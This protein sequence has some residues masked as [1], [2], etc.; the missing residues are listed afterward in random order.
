[1]T[2]PPIISSAVFASSGAPALIA[3]VDGGG[4][5]SR[6]RLTDRNGQIIGEAHAGPANIR[7]G[8]DE[9]W[10]QILSLTWDALRGDAPLAPDLSS[11][12]LGL[13]LAG[14][15]CGRDAAALAASNPGFYSVSVSSDIHAACLGAFGGKD[16][17]IVICGT[18]SSAYMLR[19]GVGRQ[20]G[21]WG[22]KICDYGSAASVG[23]GAIRAAL[24]AHDGFEAHT[25]LTTEIMAMFNNNPIELVDWSDGAIPRD[26]GRFA[27]ICARHAGNDDP[28][29]RRLI[30]K[31]AAA[32]EA[33]VLRLKALGAPRICV[34][35]GMA[36]T[37]RPYMGETTQ[38]LLT[39][40][41]GDATWGAIALARG[42][43]TGFDQ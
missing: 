29:A 26:Y 34:L 35:G 6:L 21:G 40:P 17:G 14:V 15:T 43:T 7:L 37:L 11:I 13:G 36:P 27:P 39:E 24:R 16:G 38:A 8:K 2:E 31:A 1:M 41:Q 30:S 25:R 22:F 42:A 3:G 19:D 10:R 33:Y 9:A 12:A 18:G 4:T 5:S 28:I 32:V 20:I 23:V